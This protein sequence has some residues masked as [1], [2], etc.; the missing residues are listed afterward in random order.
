MQLSHTTNFGECISAHRY[1]LHI[2]QKYDQMVLSP[3][4]PALF[5]HNPDISMGCFQCFDVSLMHHP[6]REG[7]LFHKISLNSA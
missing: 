3:H 6:H 2:Y 4:Q 5:H 7:I 1:Y